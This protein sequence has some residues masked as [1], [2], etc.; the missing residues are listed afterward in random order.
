MDKNPKRRKYRENPYKLSKDESKN[1]YIVTFRDTSGIIQEIE[2]TKEV[3][4]VFDEYEKID[5]SVMNEF[6]RHTEHSEIYKN[7]LEKRANEKIM[8]LEDDFIK[9]ATFEELKKAIDMLP[10]IQKRR[11]KK[12][13]FDDKNEYQIAEEEGSTQQAVHIILER[14]IKNLKKILKI[15]N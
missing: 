2:V 3:W 1:L 6:D 9:Q 15:F 10:E 5:I 14:A 7:S 8:S 13:Y 11:I 12:Y 4:E